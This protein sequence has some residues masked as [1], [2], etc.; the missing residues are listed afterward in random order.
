VSIAI[1]ILLP[2]LGALLPPLSARWGRRAAAW[3][4]AGVTALSLAVLLAAAP[5]ILAGESWQDGWAWVPAMGLN[6]TFRM[7]GLGFL[8]AL[9]VLG[10]GLLVILYARYY[11]SETDPM[12]RFY[13]LLLLF[14]AAMLGIVL[15]D[16]LLLL[17]IFWEMTSLS[18]FLLVGYWKHRADARQGAV[19]ALAVTGGGGLALLAGLLL[20]GSIAGSF[21]LSAIL[22]LRGV[23]AGVP[24]ISASSPLGRSR[25]CST[26]S[27]TRPSRPR[28][29]R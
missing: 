10:I 18:S 17:L 15:A 28:S 14:M 8:F 29:A 6:L 27:I 20:L 26:S 13:G 9:L 19:M 2:L 1:I 11:L 4:A 23:V 21:E 7:D 25:A 16:N 3:S 5:R 24:V 12:G 22:P